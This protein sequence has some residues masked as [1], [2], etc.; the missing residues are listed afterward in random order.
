MP[1]FYCM[2]TINKTKKTTLLLFGTIF[3]LLGCNQRTEKMK[4]GVPPGISIDAQSSIDYL[5]VHYY[6]LRFCMK[7][8][9]ERIE[10]FFSTYESLVKHADEIVDQVNEGAMPPHEDGFAPLTSCQKLVLTTWIQA[11]FPRENGPKLGASG[12]SCY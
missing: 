2:P 12:N 4:Y 1:I 6:S 7:C 5:T 10:P 9:K 3:L 8:H 11:G